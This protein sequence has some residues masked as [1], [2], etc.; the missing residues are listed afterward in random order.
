M[1]IVC[2]G[3]FYGV[4]TVVIRDS[5]LMLRGDYGEGFSTGLTGVGILRPMLMVCC[6]GWLKRD[7]F[8]TIVIGVVVTVM[9][10]LDRA[11]G[12]GCSMLL[13]RRVVILI[14]S[15]G[16]NRMVIWGDYRLIG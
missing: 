6:S 10:V 9:V 12:Y 3:A 11:T 7:G 13:S 1:S 4:S 8:S 14:M 15:E 5:V 2:I 16:S